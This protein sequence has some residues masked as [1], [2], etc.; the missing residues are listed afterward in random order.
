MSRSFPLAWLLAFTKSFALLASHVDAW[1]YTPLECTRQTN[2]ATDKQREKLRNAKSHAR[3]KPLLNSQ[4]L[5][6]YQVACPYF[7][8]GKI[9]TQQARTNQVIEVKCFLLKIPAIIFLN[10]W[11]Q[12]PSKSFMFT[13]IWGLITQSMVSFLLQVVA[14]NSCSLT[15]LVIFRMCY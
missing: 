13:A 12:F 14:P 7:R 9:T 1:F 5:T 2:Y 15:C 8:I 11:S 3:E 6:V 4:G 10:L